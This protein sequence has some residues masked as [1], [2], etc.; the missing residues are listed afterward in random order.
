MEFDERI[1]AAERPGCAASLRRVD[2]R[3]ANKKKAWAEAGRTGHF[4]RCEHCGM[5]ISPA[6]NYSEGRG[7]GGARDFVRCLTP[8]PPQKR[9]RVTIV[10]N[11]PA[12]EIV[13]AHV[14][15]FAVSTIKR[16]MRQHDSRVPRG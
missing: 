6:R 13:L 12:R 4:A 2:R 11:D 16:G 7:Y 10:V 5:L 15:F 8:S 3:M 1:P 9:W 14:N